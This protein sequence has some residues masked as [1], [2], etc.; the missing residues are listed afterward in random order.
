MTVSWPLPLLIC[1]GFCAGPLP[2]ATS[3]AQGLERATGA[4]RKQKENLAPLIDLMAERIALQMVKVEP[5]VIKRVISRALEVQLTAKAVRRYEQELLRLIA[6]DFGLKTQKEQDMVSRMIASNYLK[7]PKGRELPLAT[8]TAGLN[9]V[10]GET[11]TPNQEDQFTDLRGKT[12]KLLSLLPYPGMD[13]LAWH[14]RCVRNGKFVERDLEPLL[15]PH[16]DRAQA[17]G[18]RF[19]SK[20]YGPLLAEKLGSIKGIEFSKTLEAALNYGDTGVAMAATL[21]KLRG[22]VRPLVYAEKN[23]KRDP[24]EILDAHALVVERVCTTMQTA[25]VWEQLRTDH[26]AMLR[27]P[28]AHTARVKARGK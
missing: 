27:D 7:S 14:R 19:L 2:C 12:S 17:K 26:S 1:L 22:L 24:F 10:P 11:L 15:L 16:T 28:K 25:A 20:M 21:V 23:I 9:L 18:M 6:L 4:T 13:I 5:K 3:H 8:P